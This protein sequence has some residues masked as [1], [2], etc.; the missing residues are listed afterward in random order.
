MG[1]NLMRPIVWRVVVFCFVLA[2]GLISCVPAATASANPDHDRMASAIGDQGKSFHITKITYYVWEQKY[3]LD[4]GSPEI[5]IT[6]AAPLLI[7]ARGTCRG[8]SPAMFYIRDVSFPANPDNIEAKIVPA[9]SAR[10]VSKAFR[11]DSPG[12][13]H[14]RVLGGG[15]DWGEEVD[16]TVM[17]T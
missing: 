12:T 6:G 11:F 1:G 17:V 13:Y 7:K 4:L 10:T 15:V 5:A 16:I 9:G 3:T 8:K 2:A 14:V